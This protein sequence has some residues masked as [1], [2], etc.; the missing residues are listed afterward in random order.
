MITVFRPFP[1][2]IDACSVHSDDCLTKSSQSP[3]LNRSNRAINPSR[4]TT[5][6]RGGMQRSIRGNNRNNCGEFLGSGVYGFRFQV[7]VSEFRFQGSLGRKGGGGNFLFGEEEGGVESQV[8]IRYFSE[9]NTHVLRLSRVR[10]RP[11]ARMPVSRVCITVHVTASA[12]CSDCSH[13]GSSGTKPCPLEHADELSPPPSPAVVVN[14]VGE[15]T[16]GGQ[17]V[18]HMV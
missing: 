10:A 7:W 6:P 5:P 11:Q 16:A 14:P 18:E 3:A 1:P 4:L 13:F 8:R 15:T 9:K 17:V 2:P 12:S